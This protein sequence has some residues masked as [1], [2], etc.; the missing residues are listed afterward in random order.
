MVVEDRDGQADLEC[1]ATGPAHLGVSPH[2]TER[3]N[4]TTSPTLHRKVW[5]KRDRRRIVFRSKSEPVKKQPRKGEKRRFAISL[6]RSGFY[7]TSQ[8]IGRSKFLYL[9]NATSTR[10][11]LCP[12]SPSSRPRPSEQCSQQETLRVACT[13]GVS[14]LGHQRF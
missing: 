4:P 12:S 1:R 11:V 8:I 5:S 13:S 7:T 9:S 2:P 10:S 6:H 3:D 14:L